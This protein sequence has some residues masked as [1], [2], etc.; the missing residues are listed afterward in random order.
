MNGFLDWREIEKQNDWGLREK[1]DAMGEMWNRDAA[2]WDSRWKGEEEYTAR[3]AA[4]LDLLPTDTVLDLGCGTGPLTMN[5]AP[6]VQKI[7]AQDYGVDMLRLLSENAKARGLDNVETLQGNFHTMEPGVELPIADVVVARWSPAQG[8]ILKM[9]KCATRQCYSLMSVAPEFEKEGAS[10]GG[11]WCRSTTDDELN[12]SPRPCARKYGFNVHFNLLYDHG[13][14]PTLQ[15]V[16]SGRVVT[17][18]TYEE[19]IAAVLRRPLAVLRENDAQRRDGSQ[20]GPDALPQ[21]PDFFVRG[22][23]QL[24]DGTWQFEDPSTMVIMGWNPQDVRF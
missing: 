24:E 20:S 9:S 15:Y 17:A 21:L 16:R 10:T 14:N 7:I 6:R 1:T 2:M 22:S 3:Q 11:F 8:D 4:A 12:H 5:I 23:R 18:P 19:L 13:A